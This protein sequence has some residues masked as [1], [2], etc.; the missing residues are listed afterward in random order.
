MAVRNL[1]IYLEYQD[2]IKQLYHID[3]FKQ[4]ME[5]SI[6]MNEL[7]V[8]WLEFLNFVIFLWLTNVT[9]NEPDSLKVSFV[10]LWH[11]DCFDGLVY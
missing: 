7:F 5:C 8:T 11:H 2:M 1:H 10:S 4:S 3:I 6:K 9:M